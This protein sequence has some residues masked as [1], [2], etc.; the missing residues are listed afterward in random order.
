[1]RIVLL[2]APG[3]GKGTQ[4]ELLA[5]RYHIRQ[6]S[7]GDLLRAAVSSNSPLGRQAKIAMDAGQLVGDEIVLGIIQERI[8]RPDARNEIGR[9]H[10]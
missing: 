9:A 10:V 4:A 7:T 3:S 6:I 1:M 8:L 2:G 5:E